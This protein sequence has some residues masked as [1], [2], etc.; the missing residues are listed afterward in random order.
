[1]KNESRFISILLIILVWT[2]AC[3]Q[4]QNV[5]RLAVTTDVHGMIFPY[6]FV[7]QQA[8][9]Y[10]LA[11]VS[12]YVHNQEEKADTLF[13]LLDNGDLLQGQPSVYY[14]NFID[15][16]PPH[17]SARAMNLMGYVAGSVGNH[18][19]ETGPNVYNR[20]LKEFEF[21]WLAANAIDL[22]TGE[23]YFEPY[24]ILKAGKKKIAVLGMI[25]PGI[26]NW[27][28]GN[29]WPD[30]EFRDMVETAQKWVPFIMENEKPDLLVGLFHAGTDASYGGNPNPYLNENATLL[31]AEQVTGFDLIFAGHD[32]KTSVQ[33][34]TDPEGDSV[35]VID[36]G[37]HG[38]YVGEAT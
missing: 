8:T 2:T 5:V 31:V 36:P 19:I 12:S 33:W 17:L 3:K 18:D 13:F 37:S 7:N 25:T 10:S 34:A 6:D 20:I 11:H 14:H 30:M 35:L 26:P 23:P 27:L 21:P 22:T 4:E 24:T 28:P 38:R 32:H 29:L 9:D 1:M 16:L 15:T